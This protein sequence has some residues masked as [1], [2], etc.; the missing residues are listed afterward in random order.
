MAESKTASQLL[1]QLMAYQGGSYTP[2]TDDQLRQQATNDY[3]SYYDALNLAANQAWQRND[4]ALQQQAAGL[5][6]TYDKQRKASAENYRSLYSQADRQMLSRGMQRSS[7]GMQT[8]SN[9]GLKGQQAQQELWDQQAAAEN[10]I[11]AQRSQL[12]QQL[13]EQLTQYEANRQKD[14]LSRYDTLSDQDYDRSIAA[15]QYQNQLAMQM[16]QYQYQAEQDRIAQEQWQKQFDEGVRQFE[17]KNTKS[18]GSSSGNGGTKPPVDDAAP[19][20]T[21]SSYDQ[22]MNGLFG[23]KINLA[24]AIK[25]GADKALKSITAVKP[26]LNPSQ[27]FTDAYIK[28]TNTSLKKTVGTSSAAWPLLTI[29]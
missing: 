26:S 2:K 10:N 21:D 5:Q 13:S 4:L 27:N 25:A 29:K 16:Y 7:Y 18:S 3:A 20:D 24:D 22:L 17:A 12:A 14:I 6:S 19:Q 23:A 28:K 9:I 1:E 8:L 15:Q 11:G